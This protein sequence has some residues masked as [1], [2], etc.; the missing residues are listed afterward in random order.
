MHIEND[1]LLIHEVADH[2]FDR[3]EAMRNDQRIYLYEP[4]FLLET[5]GTPIEALKALQDVRLHIF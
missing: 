1:R 5:Q 2:D 4:T 3:L